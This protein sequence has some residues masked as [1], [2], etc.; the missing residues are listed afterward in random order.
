MLIIKQYK[1]RCECS[2]TFD[3]DWRV[4]GVDWQLQIQVT[5]RFTIKIVLLLSILL[6]KLQIKI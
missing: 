6:R 4:I 5:E 2:K 1:Q 3:R